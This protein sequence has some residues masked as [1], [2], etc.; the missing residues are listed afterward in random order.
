[1]M[2]IEI[3]VPTEVVASSKGRAYLASA[4][5]A[6]M[7][8]DAQYV[9]GPISAANSGAPAST[10]APEAPAEA[11][12]ARK[13]RPKKAAEEKQLISTGED[14]VDPAQVAEQDA[15]DEAAEVEAARDPAKPVSRDDVAAVMT[16]YVNA[17]GMAAA[18]EDGVLIYKEALG[19]PPSG[20]EGWKLSILPYDD[21]ARMA[22]VMATWARATK[23]NP[24]KRA[25]VAG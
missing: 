25:K 5:S 14:R 21:Q 23:E 22:K 8:V 11:P 20:H 16:E 7:F 1:M 18:Q 12:A 3:E 15:K 2:K 19:E 6:L 10:A 17:Y 4:M 9:G 24:L 13:G